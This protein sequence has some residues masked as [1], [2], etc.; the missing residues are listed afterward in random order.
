MS[1]AAFSPLAFPSYCFSLSAGLFLAG[2]PSTDGGKTLSAPNDKHHTH[3]WKPFDTFVSAWFASALVG[4]L[5]WRV[6]RFFDLKSVLWLRSLGILCRDNPPQTRAGGKEV[7]LKILM[8][9]VHLSVEP[10]SDDLHQIHRLSTFP[11]QIFTFLV[12][13]WALSRSRL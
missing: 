9:S 2:L 8:L 4:L 5:V 13:K 7:M 10:I 6:S 1:C 12:K 11:S 3:F